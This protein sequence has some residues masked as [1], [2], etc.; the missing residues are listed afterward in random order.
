MQTTE[1]VRRQHVYVY[2]PHGNC[3]LGTMINR[4]EDTD[5]YLIKLEDGTEMK[6]WKNDFKFID[7]TA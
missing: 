6:V 7:V 5:L 3:H 4:V 2:Y 1:Q